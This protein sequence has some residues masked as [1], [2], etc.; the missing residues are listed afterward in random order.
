LSYH[1]L[2]VQVDKDLFTLS[3]EDPAHLASFIYPYYGPIVKY[4]FYM[5]IH[6]SS[7][8]S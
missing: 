5:F 7:E 8:V 1:I 6:I 4:N 2:S 3:V